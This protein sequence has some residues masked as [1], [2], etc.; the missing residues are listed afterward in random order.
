MAVTGFCFIGFLK[1]HLMGN[2]VMYGG[3]D[4]FNT[5]AERLHSMGPLITAAELVLLGLALVHVITGLWLF[6]ENLKARPVRYQANKNAGGRSIGSRTM[7]YTGLM[8]L[9]FVV[10]HLISVLIM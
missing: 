3:K 6:L 10:Y 4:A 7:P 9:A 8:I 1:M 2:L 5:Y